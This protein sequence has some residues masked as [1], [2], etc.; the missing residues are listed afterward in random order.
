MQTSKVIGTSTYCSSTRPHDGEAPI[1]LPTHTPPPLH[2]PPASGPLDVHV[3]DLFVHASAC[4]PPRPTFRFLR[5][6]CAPASASSQDEYSY[7]NHFLYAS[8]RILLG[9][10]SLARLG[11]PSIAL[12]GG[13]L[14]RLQQTTE[15]AVSL[16]NSIGLLQLVRSCTDSLA[17]QTSTR[18]DDFHCQVR[19]RYLVYHLRCITAPRPDRMLLLSVL[20]QG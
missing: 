16:T 3:Q 4:L 1:T 20:A 12:A 5:R 10:P 17:A 11:R 6:Q 7:K 13:P 19:G 8:G 14:A 2:G 15:L 9:Y 18:C